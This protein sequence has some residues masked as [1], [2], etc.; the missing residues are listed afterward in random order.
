MLYP[1]QRLLP[2]LMKK[3][4]PS[5]SDTVGWSIL[6]DVALRRGGRPKSAART[7]EK[8]DSSVGQIQANL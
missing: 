1:G 5:V 6:L 8:Q 7:A 4:N 2:G 3:G